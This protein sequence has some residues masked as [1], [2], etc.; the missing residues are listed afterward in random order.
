MAR[1]G[2]VIVLLAAAAAGLL[3]FAPP[4]A[5]TP[6]ASFDADGRF[7]GRDASVATTEA[8]PTSSTTG[9]LTDS[10]ELTQ[11]AVLP[12][13]IER[14]AR[15]QQ[16][17]YFESSE[18]LPP[19]VEYPE[20]PVA[21]TS[22]ETAPAE[23]VIDDDTAPTPRG[24]RLAAANAE[25]TPARPRLLADPD[26]ADL[27]MIPVDE[28][29]FVSLWS[30]EDL[31]GWVVQ[32]GKPDAWQV[33]DGTIR[34]N[35]GSGGW[36]RTDD[37]YGDF[38]LKADIRLSPGGNTGIAVRFPSSGSPTLTG[39]EIQLIDDTAEKYS[40]LR[41]DQHTGSLYY[42]VP[43]LQEYALTPGEWHAVQVT[44]RGD[45]VQ[46]TIDDTVVNDVYLD[47]LPAGDDPHPLRLRPSVGYIGFQSSA[48][49]V[50]FRNIRL[51]DLMTRD[52]SGL[53][54][55]DLA[56]GTGEICPENARVTVEYVGRF[57]DGA[58]FDSS[59]DRDEPV[60]V[61]LDQVIRGWQ[62]GIP[63]MRV[64]GRRKLVVPAAL[65]YGDEGVKD[66]VPPGSTLVFEV[67]LRGVER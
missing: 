44:A 7:P 26:E 34:C 43:P 32:D 18:P 51:H 53:A 17:A 11:Q 47:Q 19:N 35:R 54:Q 9:S 24:I 56:V 6:P 58:Q 12:H 13:R 8:S 25:L 28:A 46:V 39:I 42:H 10:K 27:L 5:V 36:L 21:A 16:T 1:V 15:V 41:P 57:L 40:D 14:P 55:I 4:S 67:E 23:A 61:P 48:Q 52:E 33:T 63:G 3:W 30:G 62:V 37:I 31:A 45:R 59:Y 65:A 49:Q 2:L 66:L 29:D 22:T 38:D 20:G 64:G 60:T 50:E